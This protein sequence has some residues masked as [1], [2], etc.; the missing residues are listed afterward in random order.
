MFYSPI[1]WLHVVMVILSLA[2]SIIAV[3]ETPNIFQMIASSTTLLISCVFGGYCVGPYRP[4]KMKDLIEVQRAI[5]IVVLGNSKT[6]SWV[7]H[8]NF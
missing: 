1:F 6:A 8:C 3:M 4:G 7:T 5:W 2:V